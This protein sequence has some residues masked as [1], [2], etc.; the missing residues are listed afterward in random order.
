MGDFEDEIIEPEGTKQK[1]CRIF[2]GNGL[3]VV[4]E[5]TLNRYPDSYFAKL[6]SEDFADHKSKTDIIFIDRDGKHFASIL[7]HLRGSLNLENLT[8]RELDELF[9]EADY[10]CLTEL[11]AMISKEHDDRKIEYNWVRSSDVHML[12]KDFDKMVQFIKKRNRI[13]Y[14]ISFAPRL[15]HKFLE[16]SP[17]I[18]A[19]MKG[20]IFV[21]FELELCIDKSVETGYV[22]SVYEPEGEKIRDL[23]TSS[24]RD[25]DWNS[26]NIYNH[27]TRHFITN[28]HHDLEIF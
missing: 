2:V 23:C 3:H 6:L 16:L 19:L 12:H 1:F 13:T 24:H 11:Q 9:L 14:I 20:I 10:Y 22:L 25:L 4:S 27:L 5:D 21:K 7:N 26:Q 28:Y 17:H 8:R 18:N 15:E